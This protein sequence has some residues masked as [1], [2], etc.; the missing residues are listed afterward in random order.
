MN[1]DFQTIFDQLKQ[2]LVKH[3]PPLT[4]KADKSDSYQLYS[5]KDLVI[6]GKKVSEVYFAGVQ[7]QKNFVGFYFF[8]IYTH[9]QMFTDT[10][11]EL[12]K[13]LKGKSCF[14]VKKTDATALKQF[15]KLIKQ[16]FKVY[17]QEKWI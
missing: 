10:P 17:K 1:A 7:I 4:V 13:C 3:A 9:P 5:V 14:N 6:T 11:E 8:P 15:E 16:G 12:R 2:L